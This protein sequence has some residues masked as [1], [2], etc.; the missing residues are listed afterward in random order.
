MSAPRAESIRSRHAS[1]ASG[2]T[3]MELL[4][5]LT[6]VALLF[7]IGVPT[8]R[9]ASLGS[10]LAAA[11]NDL[12]ASVQLA[13]SEA[14]KRNV[15]VTLCPSTD[16]A[17]CDVGADWDQGWIVVDEGPDPDE[18]IQVQEA[19]DDGY[20]MTQAG[21]SAE[22]AFRPIGI[23][24]TAATITVCRET[25]LG[26]QERVLNVTAAGTVYISNTTTGDCP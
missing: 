15:D 5:T 2:F 22:L 16:G 4:V 12:L 23:G 17:A 6:I 26:S 1:P 24:A 7:A 11:A 25:P 19:L 21:G 20:R 18:L 10:R 9:N 8:F 13:R 14:I 3:L